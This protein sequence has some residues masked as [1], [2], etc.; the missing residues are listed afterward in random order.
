VGSLAFDVE[1]ESLWT[2][3]ASCGPIDGVRVVRDKAT[4]VGKGFG[5]GMSCCTKAKKCQ[6][7]SPMTSVFAY[8]MSV[9][10]S[11]V[12]FKDRESVS[13]ALEL[14]DTI[15]GK[16]KIRVSR[17]LKDDKLK[18]TVGAQRRLFEGERAQKQTGPKKKTKTSTTGSKPKGSRPKSPKSTQGGPMASKNP[19]AGKSPKGPK[20]SAKPLKSRTRVKT[21]HKSKQ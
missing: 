9:L 5:Y 6:P 11:T 18:S 21:D 12:E 14:N 1:E 3:F 16:R 8:S 20:G 15:Q 2:W 7:G 4:N 17:C 13:N 10:S 19:K